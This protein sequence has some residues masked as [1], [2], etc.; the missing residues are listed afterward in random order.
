MKLSIKK[1]RKLLH[2]LKTIAQ[3]IRNL[4]QLALIDTEAYG[5]EIIKI[6]DSL[7]HHYD[8]IFKEMFK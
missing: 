6:A 1:E 5:E 4:K 8:T 3:E 2:E 7:A